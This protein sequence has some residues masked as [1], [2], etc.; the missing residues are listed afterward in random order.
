MIGTV[1]QLEDLQQ[2]TGYQR[3]ADVERCLRDQGIRY[4]RGSY[5]PHW[6]TLEWIHQAAGLNTS[7]APTEPAVPLISRLP[8]IA[9]NTIIGRDE[10]LRRS[11]LMNDPNST[12]PGGAGIYFLINDGDIR[13]IGQSVQIGTRVCQHALS[14]RQFS[15]VSWVENIPKDA[16]DEI[17]AFYIT[18][19]NPAENVR[20][21][22][23]DLMP[24]SAMN[25]Y[26]GNECTK[27]RR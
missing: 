22:C 15:A 25:A 1:I 2:I 12:L 5:S 9:Q 17:E 26:L 11:V 21:P 18:A 19:L 24:R 14:G 7:T 13:Y 8:D 27:A 4:S 20:R 3:M 23:P 10:I 6:T 16:L